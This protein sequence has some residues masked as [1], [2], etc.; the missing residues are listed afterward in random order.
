MIKIKISKKILEIQ[1]S[2]NT[3]EYLKAGNPPPD[4]TKGEFVGMEGYDP[5]DDTLGYEK[6]PT[7]KEEEYEIDEE[8]SCDCDSCMD[9]ELQEYVDI[10]EDL[11]Y[12][13]KDRCYYLAK[14]KY[15][16]FP[17]AYASGFIVRCRKGKVGRKKKKS[18]RKNESLDLEILLQQAD[19][20]LEGTFDKEEA[21]GLR[22]WFR[23]RGGRGKSKG[24]V[25]C[26]T[27]RTNP[28]TGRKTCKTCG[29]QSGEKRS[30]YPA[31]RPTPAACTRKGTSSKRG[32]QRVSWKKKKINEEL[33]KENFLQVLQSKFEALKKLIPNLDLKTM[34]SKGSQI[35]AA[36]NELKNLKAQSIQEAKKNPS[37]ASRTRTFNS[38]WPVINKYGLFA[39]GLAIAIMQLAGSP[40]EMPN[41]AIVDMI[42]NGLRGS[43]VEQF[44]DS[45]LSDPSRQLQIADAVFS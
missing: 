21:E 43:S 10:D 11:L 7:I 39:G 44:V 1:P 27:C 38:V 31:C 2:Q 29:R 22:G 42:A 45:A 5:Q 3:P 4:I 17:S 25:D 26:N 28:K 6:G 36:F 14:Q 32:P 30:K 41:A 9:E 19:K 34:L 8:S 20:L 18:R 15:D 40:P 35:L 16:V 37:F 13:K 33:L 12:E 23:R 24:W